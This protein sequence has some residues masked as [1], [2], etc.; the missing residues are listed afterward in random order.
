MNKILLFD[1]DCNL[2][3]NTVR[4]ILKKNKDESIYFASLQS[5]FAKQL[6]QQYNINIASLSTLVFID[7]EQVYLRSSAALRIAR[8]LQ[9]PFP[10][11]QI[12]AIVPLFLRDAVYK[13]IA[14]NRKRFFKNSESC[15][16]PSEK[17]NKRFLDRV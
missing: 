6:L 13:L 10:L 9:W 17:L 12:F 11:L 15:L 5:D 3:S 4:Y 7:N 1:G 16:M 8:Y 2:C 14:K